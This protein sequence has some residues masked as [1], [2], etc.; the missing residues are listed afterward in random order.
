MVSGRPAI[1]EFWRSFFESGIKDVALETAEVE[2]A[3]DLAYET[4]T[5]Q[6]VAED[7]GVTTA[8]YLV[9]WKR[10]DGEWRMHRDTWNSAE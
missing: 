6:L 3:G 10:T 8:R 4:G 1:A 5:V 2:S 9:V 7:G